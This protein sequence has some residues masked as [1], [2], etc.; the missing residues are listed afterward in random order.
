MESP[1]LCDIIQ[2]DNDNTRRTIPDKEMSW[3]MESPFDCFLSHHY[4]KSHV[5]I[6]KDSKNQDLKLENS[7]FEASLELEKVPQEKC[8]QS[9][10]KNE[11]NN[12]TVANGNLN[13]DDPRNWSSKKKWL[14][15]AII[16]IA[17]ISHPIATM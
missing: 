3:I 17:G 7:S 16:T 9:F 1:N 8:E 11:D 12:S 4:E 14:V 13:I 10:P 5:Y 6:N 15:L 2:I